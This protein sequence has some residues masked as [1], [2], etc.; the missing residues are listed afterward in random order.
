MHRRQILAFLASLTAAPMALRAAFAWPDQSIR[1]IVPFTPA[2]GPDMIAR[3]VAERLSPRISQPVVVENIPGASGNIGSQVVA[4]AKP[5]GNTLMSSVN[6]L[7]M[8]ASLFRDLPYDPIADFAPISLS[9]WG[10]L[11]LVAHPGQAPTTLAALIAAAEAAPKTFTYGSPGVG[12]PHHLAMALVETT[13]GIEL[14]HVPYKGAAGALQDILSGQIGYM[15][16][17]V[18]VASPHINGGRLKA[19]AV[20]SPQRAPLLPDVPTLS[21]AGLNGVDVDM[22]YGFFAPHGTPA[23]IVDRLNKDITAVLGTPEAK[24]AFEAQGLIPATSTPAA[25]GEIVVRDRD[26][27]ANVVAKRGL[28]PA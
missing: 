26:R 22:W 17:P 1:L 24:T 2:G 21:E 13:T 19:F 9:A 5:D 10:T 7:V 11:V 27:W 14:L 3:Y 4:R 8:N 25:L 6:T 16:L 12:T 23:D 28:K 18:H 15:F 20:G